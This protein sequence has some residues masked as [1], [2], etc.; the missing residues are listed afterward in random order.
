MRAKVA[1][2]KK[3]NTQEGKKSKKRWDSGGKV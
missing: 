2:R 3:A 1:Q